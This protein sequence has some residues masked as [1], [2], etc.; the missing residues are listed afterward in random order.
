MIVACTAARLILA[1]TGIPRIRVR[2]FQQ[3][4]SRYP[5]EAHCARPDRSG[6]PGPLSVPD[7][8]MNDT[9]SSEVK[10]CALVKS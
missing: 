7:Q 4:A 1:T 8:G 9:P 2:L 5:R 6:S 10:H 3:W